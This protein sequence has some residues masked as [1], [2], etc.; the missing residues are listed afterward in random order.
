MVHNEHNK[1]KRSGSL[2]LIILGAILFMIGP[3]QYQNSPELGIL[4]LVS[5]FILG[6]IGFYLKYVKGKIIR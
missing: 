6:G 1:P 2:L 3:T 5:G 4:A